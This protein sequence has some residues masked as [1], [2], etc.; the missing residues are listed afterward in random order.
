MIKI[1]QYLSVADLASLCEANSDFIS[2]AVHCFRRFHACQLAICDLHI[3]DRT[4]YRLFVMMLKYLGDSAKSISIK[5]SENIRSGSYG[6]MVIKLLAKYY[7]ASLKSI[8]LEGLHIDMGYCNQRTKLYILCSMVNINDWKFYNCSLANCGPLFEY[9]VDSIERLLVYN[10]SMDVSTKRKFVQHY[11]Q[12][13]ALSLGNQYGQRSSPMTPKSFRTLLALNS[14]N[15]FQKH[16][17]ESLQLIMPWCQ[18]RL[19]VDLGPQLESLALTVN[20]VGIQILHH[21]W[22]RAHATNVLKALPSL[23]SLRFEFQH[24]HYFTSCF[25]LEM[26]LEFDNVHELILRFR[27]LSLSLLRPVNGFT[28]LKIYLNEC[29]KI[30]GKNKVSMLPWTAYNRDLILRLF[31]EANLGKTFDRINIID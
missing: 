26:I 22:L 12:M 29:R 14:S 17:T 3:Y 25:I 18:V 8:S 5:K 27:D 20:H 28:H 24:V 7:S 21:N 6:L 2:V 9:C 10:T 4:N 1:C 11:P 23:R 15:L 19:A 31:A 30:V 16:L 13:T